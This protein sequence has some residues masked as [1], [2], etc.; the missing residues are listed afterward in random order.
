M[1]GMSDPV[2]AA[3]DDDATRSLLADGLPP[4]RIGIAGLQHDP[5]RSWPGVLAIREALDAAQG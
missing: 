3:T 5:W 4:V 1:K 2:G